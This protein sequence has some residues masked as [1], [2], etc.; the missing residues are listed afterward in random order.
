MHG[1]GGRRPRASGMDT[2]PLQCPVS[3]EDDR[4]SPVGARVRSMAAAL[5]AFLAL[6]PAGGAQADQVVSAFE[7]VCLPWN[8][9]QYVAEKYFLRMELDVTARLLLAGR[10]AAAGCGHGRSPAVHE[11]ARTGAAASGL[12]FHRVGPA[13][14]DCAPAS[15]RGAAVA[16]GVVQ[17][18]HPSALLRGRDTGC[19]GARGEHATV[20]PGRERVAHDR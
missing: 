17:C 7:P 12:S 13:T 1:I 15:G 6:L 11:P 4:Y 2:G 10:R 3:T 8:Q 9:A 18:R 19:T 14:P 5:L 20:P 16:A